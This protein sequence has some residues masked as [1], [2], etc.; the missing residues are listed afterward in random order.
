MCAELLLWISRRYWHGRRG[1]YNYSPDVTLSNSPCG[2]SSADRCGRLRLSPDRWKSDTLWLHFLSMALTLGFQ[3]A[4]PNQIMVVRALH[5]ALHKAT[6]PVG[7][8]IGCPGACRDA[9]RAA[10]PGIRACSDSHHLFRASPIQSCLAIWVPGPSS[11]SN[12][13]GTSAP[14]DGGPH[15]NRAHVRTL[16]RACGL[17]F[18]CMHCHLS[19]LWNTAQIG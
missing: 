15:F 11:E 13:L 3:R 2:R 19:Q 18:D 14:Q 10:G 6:G 16:E 9:G 17:A 8:W 1:F 7:D 5:R 12:P 4:S